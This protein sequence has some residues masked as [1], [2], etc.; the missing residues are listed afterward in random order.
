MRVAERV[1]VG[2]RGLCSVPEVRREV[3]PGPTL[4]V[5][6]SPPAIRSASV[7]PESARGIGWLATSFKA[8]PVSP[9]RRASFAILEHLRFPL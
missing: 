9:G 4:S 7:A 5:R 3:G 8:G 6:R 2:S 1:S